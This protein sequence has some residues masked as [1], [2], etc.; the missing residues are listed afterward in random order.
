[1]NTDSDFS[2]F[3]SR[4][5]DNDKQNQRIIQKSKYL[6]H[7]IT[8]NVMQHVAFVFI[9]PVVA[10]YMFR[11]LFEPIIRSVYELYMQI[12]VQSS[13]GMVSELAG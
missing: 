11:V 8:T 9:T 13:F 3:T 6:L 12:L 1:M 5:N 10:L 2:S 7:L 4:N